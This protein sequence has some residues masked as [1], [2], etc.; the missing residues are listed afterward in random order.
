MDTATRSARPSC[1]PADR[2]STGA[3]P[4]AGSAA[5]LAPCEVLG[6]RPPEGDEPIPLGGVELREVLLDAFGDLHLGC[7]EVEAA[8]HGTVALEDECPVVQ[9]ALAAEPLGQAAGPGP[10]LARRLV[11]REGNDVLQARKG[12]EALG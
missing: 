2:P 3:G 1:R 5:E 11:S 8:G 10:L 9:P 12:A 6:H 7:H 4:C